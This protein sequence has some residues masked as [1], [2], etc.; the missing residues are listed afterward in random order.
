ME[1]GPVEVLR[2]PKPRAE[3]LPVKPAAGLRVN[4]KKALV[5]V[6]R[7]PERAAAAALLEPEAEVVVPSREKE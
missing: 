7:A 1:D 5:A 6:L 4:S 2:V 3:R